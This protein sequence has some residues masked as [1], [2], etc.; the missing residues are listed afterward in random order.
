MWQPTPVLKRKTNVLNTMSTQKQVFNT[1]ISK[2]VRGTNIITRI[3]LDSPSAEK[4]FAVTSFL[5][6]RAAERQV[7]SLTSNPSSSG[8]RGKFQVVLS[9]LGVLLKSAP[10]WFVLQA[11]TTVE[12]EFPTRSRL[13]RHGR[14]QY[15]GILAELHMLA[16]GVAKCQP[17]L[18]QIS[19][20]IRLM[21]EVYYIMTTCISGMVSIGKT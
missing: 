12:N 9:K 20:L 15:S 16:V 11:H 19:A 4:I 3:S 21:E 7:C 13:G 6:D 1:G 10:E 14:S 8:L 18:M 17:I 2:S 5:S